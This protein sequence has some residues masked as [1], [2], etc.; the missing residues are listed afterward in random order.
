M[1]FKTQFKVP[2]KPT[3]RA[4]R[5]ILRL[6]ADIIPHLSLASVVFL[7]TLF[8][9]EGSRPKGG[10]KIYLQRFKWTLVA[11]LSTSSTGTRMYVPSISHG[12]RAGSRFSSNLTNMART[13][14]VEPS[15]FRSTR[16]PKRSPD[17]ST[18]WRPS[19]S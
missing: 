17:E 18:T 3:S 1:I 4:P 14:P 13:L 10:R 5:R 7:T 9:L 12:R 16:V 8:G 6:L 15:I 2:K 11:I 19:N